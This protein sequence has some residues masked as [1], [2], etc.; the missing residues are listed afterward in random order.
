MKNNTF[1]IA[2][3]GAGC[4]WC[5]EAIFERVNGVE[6]VLSGYSGGKIANP[7]YR[8]VSSGLTGHAEVVQVKFNPSV[9]SY[10]KILEIFFKTHN[11]TMLNRQGADVGTQYRSVIFYHTDEQ[12]SVAEDVKNMLSRAAIWNDPIV[13]E[14]SPFTKFYKAEDYHQ[15]YLENNSKQPYCQMVILPKIDK[16][17]KLFEDYLKK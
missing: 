15:N 5:V 8:E 11:P 3:L 6:E 13:T 9:I 7:T 2:T 10:A 16:F 17:E 14:I 12:K 4:F 1:E